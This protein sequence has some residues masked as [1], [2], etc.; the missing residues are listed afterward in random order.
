MKQK[1][2]NKILELLRVLYVLA[3]LPLIIMSIFD[4]LKTKDIAS[5]LLI[6]IPTLIAVTAGDLCFKYLIGN[7]E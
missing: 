6:I 3:W 1:T 4:L 2:A 5:F 7:E